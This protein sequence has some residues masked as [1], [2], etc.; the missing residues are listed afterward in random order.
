MIYKKFRTDPF[1]QWFI[2][3]LR[4][5][6]GLG[7]FPSG[8]VKL[9]GERF[10]Q[11]TAEDPIGYFFEALYQSGFYYNSIGL[12]QVVAGFLL[13]TQRF[14]SFGAIIYACIITNIWIITISLQF[15]GTWII[16]TLMLLATLL[17]LIWDWEKYKSIF[18]YNRTSTYTSYPDPSPFWQKLGLIYFILLLGIWFTAHDPNIAGIITAL[19]V[20]LLIGTNIYAY[21]RYRKNKARRI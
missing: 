14:S 7:F 8:L 17:L 9:V 18:A 20:L 10:T 1:C 19:G 6:L 11:I 2:I 12:I 4:Y 5:L 13:I 3:H 21:I 15:K 16:T